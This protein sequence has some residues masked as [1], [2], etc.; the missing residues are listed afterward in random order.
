MIDPRPD[1]Q[2]APMKNG[3]GKNLMKT[4]IKIITVGWNQTHPKTK[5]AGSH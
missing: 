3:A 5:M 2:H 4:A 1:K